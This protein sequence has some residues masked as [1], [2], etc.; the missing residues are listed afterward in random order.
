VT[1]E[2][3]KPEVRIDFYLIAESKSNGYR[4][5]VFTNGHLGYTEVR[6][7]P[8]QHNRGRLMTDLLDC[9]YRAVVRFKLGKTLQVD[10]VV[11]VAK[12]DGTYGGPARVKEID[13]DAHTAV[14]GGKTV[15]IR[16]LVWSRPSKH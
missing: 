8:G 4:M 10:D 13:W 3:G 16:R 5:D 14:V 9:I 11:R 2:D 12:D 6:S 15:P 7:F 1:T